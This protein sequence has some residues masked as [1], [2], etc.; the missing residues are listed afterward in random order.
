[1]AT[2]KEVLEERLDLLVSGSWSLLIEELTSMATS[3][4]NI[5]N[6]DDEK[7]LFLRRGQVDTLNM[8]IN[9]KETTRLALDQL[10]D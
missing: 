9:L 8:I 6:I 5:N 7:T 2:D 3:L 1:V 4:E 10:E